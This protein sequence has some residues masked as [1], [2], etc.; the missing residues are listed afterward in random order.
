LKVPYV[1]AGDF[2]APPSPPLSSGWGWKLLG[3]KTEQKFAAKMLCVHFMFVGLA[4]IS[5]FFT[6]NKRNFV[7]YVDSKNINKIKTE[8]LLTKFWSIL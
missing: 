7:L 8:L 2:I 3:S 4:D 1:T 6:L 5:A